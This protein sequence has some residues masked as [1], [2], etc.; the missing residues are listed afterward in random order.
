MCFGVTDV[1]LVSLDSVLILDVRADDRALA[2]R[3]AHLATHLERA[4][5]FDPTKRGD[6]DCTHW[7]DR[8]L[9]AE[10][11]AFAT[12]IRVA[13]ALGVRTPYPFAADPN[14]NLIAVYLREHPE[15][16]EG[17]EPLLVGYEKRCRREAK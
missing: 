5:L 16:S 7:V 17:I 12:E 3:V 4:P 2:A 1:S 14:P 13:Q 6:V 9:R 11:E 15:P 10:G 8:V